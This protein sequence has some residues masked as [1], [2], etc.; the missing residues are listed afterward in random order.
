MYYFLY[1]IQNLEIILIDDGCKHDWSKY[2]IKAI[3][4]KNSGVSKARNTG[5][6]NA[7]GQYITFIDSDDNISID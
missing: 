1:F 6:D 2:P 3:H 4:Q 5:L 7:I